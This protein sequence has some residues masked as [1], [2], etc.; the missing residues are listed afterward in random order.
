MSADL[1]AVAKYSELLKNAR[2]NLVSEVTVLAS[3]E[4]KNGQ[5]CSANLTV[6]GKRFDLVKMNSSYMPERIKALDVIRL[7]LIKY[8]QGVVSSHRSGVDGL[9]WRLR[10]ASAGVSA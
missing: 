3:L 4:M 6:C 10:Q 5:D 1:A 9:E 2:L 7:E 8:Q